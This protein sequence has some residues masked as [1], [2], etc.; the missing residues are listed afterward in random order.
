MIVEHGFYSRAVV[1]FQARLFSK[2]WQHL[3]IYIYD[4]ID[5]SYKIS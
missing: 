4:S 1:R 5:S 2:V 3:Y